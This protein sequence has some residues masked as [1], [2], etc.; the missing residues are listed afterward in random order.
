MQFVDYVFDSFLQRYLVAES[1]R[2]I[3]L[4]SPTGLKK[5]ATTGT[6]IDFESFHFRL[7]ESQIIRELKYIRERLGDHTSE[8][9]Q[10]YLI[11]SPSC[12]INYHA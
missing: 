1:H 6:I 3:N 5:L 2:A 7:T 11:L 8:R 4:I 12:K 9:K 10:S